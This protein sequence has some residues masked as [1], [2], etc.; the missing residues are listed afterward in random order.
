MD[1]LLRYTEELLKDFQIPLFPDDAREKI[2]KLREVIAFHDKKYYQD[3]N[4]L[5]SDVQYDKLYKLLKDIEI[6]FPELITNDSPT[7]RISENV[8]EGFASVAHLTPMLS[9]DNS[10]NEEDLLEFNKRLLSN[11]PDNTNV[12]YAVE[13]KF[14]G[15]SIAIVYENDLMVRAA[16][17]GNGIEGE[18]ITANAKTIKSIPLRVPF[19]KYGIYKVEVRGEVVI[20]FKDFE[21]L[22]QERINQNKELVLQGKRPLELFKNARNT[23]AGTLRLKNPKDVAE[24]KLEAIIYQL[25]RMEDKEGKEVNAKDFKSHFRN[26][27]ILH[28]LGFR[29]P[30]EE[31]RL[32]NS[33]EEI[34][35]YCREWEEKR[36]GYHY[37]IDGM[38]IKL[39]NIPMQRVAGFTA[40]HPRWA[41]A[42]KFKARQGITR[43]KNVEFQVGRTGAV[44]PV[45]KLEP[46][47]LTGVEI[48]SV[49]L[50]NEEFITEREIL[51][52]DFVLVE[53]AGDVIPYIVASVKERRDGTQ[54]KIEFPKHCPSCSEPLYKNEEE[55]VWR[56]V[57][58]LCPAQQEERLKHFVSKGA[59]DIDGLGKDI[60]KRFV[61][62]KIISSITD[63]YQLDYERILQLDGW[64]EKSVNNLKSSIE[65][66][67][68]NPIWRLITALGIRHVGTTMAKKIAS[69]VGHVKDFAE[70]DTERLIAL[71][72]VGPKVAESI[73]EF[74]SDE[75]N[76]RLLTTLGELGVNLENKTSTNSEEI[77][78]GKLQ[79]KSF[80]FTGS[81][82]LFTREEAQELVE[83]NGGKNLSSVSSKLDFLVVGENAGSKL[84]KAQKIPSVQILSEEAF[85]SMIEE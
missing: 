56:C 49:S 79:G 32:F 10:Y 11:L 45:A 69:Q 63:I 19:S 27:D 77:L 58:A 1:I 5:I 40:H 13:P 43:L 9:L 39:D 46:V 47:I 50:H 83:K 64:K 60:V 3:N 55:A 15:S 14:D 80:L 6:K 23:A 21:R 75:S 18:D 25:G 67:K 51:L 84:A 29:V 8:N 22:N 42:F 30:K 31:K 72:D 41:I 54:K 70:W 16:T 48:S 65:K 26:L 81:L 57:N 17:R 85:K 35:A 66:S 74:F 44:T 59:M 68:E 20:S 2:L 28:E 78:S 7:Q 82:S 33:V 52:N 37:E 61:E 62:E 53:R 38:V 71:D 73:H 76:I 36:L 24:R 4:P 34:I 12:E